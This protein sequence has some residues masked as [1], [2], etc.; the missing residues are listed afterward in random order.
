MRTR[1]SVQ[2]ALFGLSAAVVFMVA[3]L[4]ANP[5]LFILGLILTVASV[6]PWMRALRR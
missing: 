1:D 2:C 6:I 5:V 4:I 3:W